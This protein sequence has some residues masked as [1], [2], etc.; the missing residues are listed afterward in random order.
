MAAGKGEVVGEKHQRLAGFGIL[1]ADA[2]Q[3]RRVVLAGGD[4]IQRDGLVANDTRGAIGRRRVDAMGIH[5]RLGARDEKG[6]GLVQGMKAREIDV[7]AIH[8]VDGAR[9]RA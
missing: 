4:A 5:V 2:A 7:G 6:T 1:E 3:M 9:L 8:D